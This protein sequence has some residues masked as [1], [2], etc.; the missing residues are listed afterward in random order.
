[1]TGIHPVSNLR[2]HSARSIHRT[3]KRNVQKTSKWVLG[4]KKH[5]CAIS[6]IAWF[7]GERRVPQ[8]AAS[9]EQIS[10]WIAMWRGFDV[11][12]GR[13]IRKVWGK[14]APTLAKD[15]RKWNQA[16]GP[17]SA[18]ICS[19]FGSGLEVEHTRFFGKRQKPV[20]LLDGALLNKAQIMECL[21]KDMEMQMW[22]KA[23]G[24]PL[25]TG[26]EKGMN[27]DLAKKARSQL[28]K[29]GNFMVHV[30]WTFLFAE[31]ST[32]LTCLRMDKVPTNFSVFVVTREPWPPG[33]TNCG[34]VLTT[35]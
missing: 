16:T 34:N 7:F 18:T 23:A 31:P 20:L 4:K 22:E 6:T 10:E 32:N 24:H 29:E 35:L 30:R 14:K 21:S 28:I 8:I 9:V 3:G 1:M 15:H 26:M 5:A 33:N 13:R 25:S 17:I 11:G 27:T 19:V 12:T 2:P